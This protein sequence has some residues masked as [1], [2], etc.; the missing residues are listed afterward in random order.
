MMPFN[1]CSPSPIHHKR[2][3]SAFT[4]LDNFFSVKTSSEI[5]CTIS[6]ITSQADQQ[7]SGS[8]RMPRSARKRDSDANL[9]VFAEKKMSELSELKRGGQVGKNEE[10]ER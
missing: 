1:F 2:L 10:K 8:N 7:T 9:R 3:A 4:N 5:F 6:S